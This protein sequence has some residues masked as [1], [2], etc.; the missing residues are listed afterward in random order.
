MNIY[1]AGPIFTQR[2]IDWNQKLANGIRKAYPGSNLYLAQENKSIN[3]KSKFADSK[4]IFDGDFAR[5]KEADILIAT[6]SGDMPPIGTSCEVAIYSEIIAENPDCG[7]RLICLYDDTRD[8]TINKEKAIYAS[9]NI[10]ENQTCY[11]NLLLIGAAKRNGIIVRDEQQ[12]FEYIEA[13]YDD[14]CEKLKTSG[15]YCF[16]NRLNNKK[17]IGQ[18]I[19]L[20]RRIKE[21]WSHHG[22]KH[23]SAIDLALEK[24]GHDIFTVEIL[25]FCSREE[26]N[27]KESYWIKTLNTIAPNGYNLTN[28]GDHTFVLSNCKQ[29]S[30]YDIEGNK[31][32]TFNSINDACRE[33]GLIDSTISFCCQEK[34][35]YKSCGGMIWRYGDKE[36]IMTPE[37]KSGP[38]S[39]KKIYCYDRVSKKLIKEYSHSKEAA[40]DIGKENGESNIRAAC[41]GKFYYVYGYIWSEYKWEVAPDNY[42]QLNYNKYQVIEGA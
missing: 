38:F 37:I 17:Y 1:L 36:T 21:H 12:L 6:I 23:N 41:R 11:T 42:K 40:I 10:A 39:K 14:D 33:Y 3:D 8:M 35:G 25:E 22:I 19:D 24:Y 31:I 27:N 5:L 20:N 2:D 13:I 15:I 26:L 7:K 32:K 30:C 4:A 29:V 16:T 28:G 9:S 18:S 34:D